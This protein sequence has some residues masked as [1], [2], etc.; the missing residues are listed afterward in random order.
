MIKVFRVEIFL[1]SRSVSQR[2]SIPLRKNVFA[3]CKNCDYILVKKT[4][5]RNNKQ[6]EDVAMFYHLILFPTSPSFTFL[7]CV[8]IYSFLDAVVC[9]R[10]TSTSNSSLQTPTC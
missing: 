7:Q 4:K 3:N 5:Q 1:P 6:R 9:V 10:T 8:S 2:N